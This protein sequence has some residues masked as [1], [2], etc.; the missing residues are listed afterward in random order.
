MVGRLCRDV[1]EMLLKQGLSRDIQE[2]FQGMFKHSSEMVRECSRCGFDTVQGWI[3]ND[4]GI[5]SHRIRILHDDWNGWILFG[6]VQGKFRLVLE[7]SYYL[8]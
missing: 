2:I 1:I 5:R 7:K 6:L 4:R 3:R 8:R